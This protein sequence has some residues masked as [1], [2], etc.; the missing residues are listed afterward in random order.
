VAAFRKT[1]VEVLV[2]GV[3]AFVLGAG[4]NAMR[5]SGSIK[6]SKNYFEPL[7]KDKHSE[8]PYQVVTFEELAEVFGDP[9]RENGLYVFVDAR[10]EE[11]FAEGHIEGALRCDPYSAETCID[12]VL[13]Y[14]CGADKVIIYCNGG[15]CE[16]SIFM[17]RELV[18][19]GYPIEHIALYSGG[20]EE[21][22]HKAMPTATGC[23]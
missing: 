6:W 21:W 14:A 15:D 20:W 1:V 19:A 5:E 7:P 2:L 22:E 8:H 23:E 12:R 10:S 11:A 13:D 18:D 17:C 4:V 3:V 16:D 9:D